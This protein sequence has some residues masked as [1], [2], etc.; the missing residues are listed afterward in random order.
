MKTGENQFL[1]FS[2]ISPVWLSRLAESPDPCNGWRGI[3]QPVLHWASQEARWGALKTS[4]VRQHQCC[5]QP[6]I[7]AVKFA[8][9]WEIDR[10]IFSG[11]VGRSQ[12]FRSPDHKPIYS[13]SN[14]RSDQHVKLREAQVRSLLISSL[15]LA[16]SA[17]PGETHFSCGLY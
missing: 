2:S 10:R 12:L 5:M 8:C 9:S 6:A 16:T 13:H 3:S 17:T 15:F 1:R 11:R 4:S 14:V 7:A